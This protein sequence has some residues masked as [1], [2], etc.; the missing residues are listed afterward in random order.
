MIVGNI[1]VIEVIV[2]CPG[3]GRGDIVACAWVFCLLRE[4]VPETWIFIVLDG[5]ELA[6]GV[7]AEYCGEGIVEEAED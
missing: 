7:E 5:F 1:A 6:I 4:V 3:G 2:D